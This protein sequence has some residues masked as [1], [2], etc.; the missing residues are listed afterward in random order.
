M[1]MQNENPNF[2]LAVDINEEQRLRSVFWVDAKARLDYRYFSDVVLL[3]S[4]HVKN[5]CRLPF[6]P[7]VGVNHHLKFLL[8]GLAFVCDGSESA[9][10]WLM[11]NWL[12]AMG[13][14]AP[15]VMVMLTDCDEVLRNFIFKNNSKCEKN[16]LTNFH[17]FTISK[18]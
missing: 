17:S 11:R 13:E 1:S 9:F 7:L 3:D 12:R 10:V 5:E 2:F 14:R 15:K 6:V 4:T 16:E 8:L 18:R